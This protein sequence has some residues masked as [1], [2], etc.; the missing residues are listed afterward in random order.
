MESRVPLGA[1]T[2]YLM[3]LLPTISAES[4]PPAV[5]LFPRRMGGTARILSAT[6]LAFATVVCLGAIAL[7]W[8][9]ETP[10]WWF[11][12]LLTIILLLLPAGFWAG[13]ASAV[14]DGRWEGAAQQQWW[15]A[16]AGAGSRA[17][18]G[19]V[20]VRQVNLREDGGVSS[21]TLTVAGATSA[22]PEVS[23]ASFDADWHRPAGQAADLL[24]PQVPG[25][26]AL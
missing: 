23:L 15:E 11:G 5:L 16:G 9:E 19:T 6:V 20:T 14:R 12:A 21:F 7:P 17:Y 3:H 13:Y 8:T 26:G 24:Q 10:G 4:A 22:G 18:R 25:V 2:L 1:D